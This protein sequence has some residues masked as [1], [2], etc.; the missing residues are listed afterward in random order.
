MEAPNEITGEDGRDRMGTRKVAGDDTKRR[1]GPAQSPQQVS[2][3]VLRSIDDPAICKYDLRLHDVVG[4][5]T[6]L[7]AEE[8]ESTEQYTP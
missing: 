2:V 5:K 1:A 6:M 8:T 7:T 3:L 4:A